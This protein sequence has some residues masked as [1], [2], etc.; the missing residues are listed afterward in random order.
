MPLTPTK[1]LLDEA[2]R[3]NYAVG[4][5]NV[6][7]MEQ[8]QAIMQAAKE[9]NSPVIL[10]ASR[11]ALKYTNMVYIKHLVEAA[12]EDNPAIPIA[13]NL[14]HGNSLEICKTAISLGFTS[15]MMDGSLKEDGK[16]PTTF[17]ENVN[18]TREVVKYAHQLGI[19]VEGEL[20]SFGG[21]EDG[22]G[23]GKMAL[24][25]PDE[26]VK[27]IKE[28]GVDALALSFGTSHGLSKFK[29]N[30]ELKFEILEKVSEAFPYISLVMHGSSSILPEF[31]SLI[32]SYGGNLKGAAGVPISEIQ[33]AIKKGIRKINIDS[34]GR[35]AMTGTIR[36]YFHD[37]PGVTDPRDYL[38]AARN[39]IYEVYKSKMI[40]FGTAGHAQDYKPMTIKDMKEKIKK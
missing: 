34:D 9:T 17:E 14:D 19:T 38:G 10:Q 25:D 7:N 32:N 1:Q 37:H 12:I 4:A 33:K 13:L 15:V 26:A 24:T 20:G 28:T 8:V 5:Y 35:L 2:I 31:I 30:P 36:K 3:G 40:D 6:N 11:G 39:S 16:T 23:S 27:F 18:I 29:G 21:F 22:H